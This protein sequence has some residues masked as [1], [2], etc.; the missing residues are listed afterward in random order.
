MENLIEKI[1]SWVKIEF[2]I[3]TKQYSLV[4]DL[5]PGV[6]WIWD[7]KEE[8]IKEY[9]SSLGDLILLNNSK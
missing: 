7:S 4:N 9:L 8:A 1:S 2:D 3:E 5:T 6:Y